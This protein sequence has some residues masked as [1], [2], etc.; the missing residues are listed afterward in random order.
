MRSPRPTLE[1]PDHVRAMLA[2][3]DASAVQRIEQFLETSARS[4]AYFTS[5]RVSERP[6]KRG[7]LGRLTGSSKAEPQLGP[8]RSKFGG[9]P[10][11][12][13][14]EL[15]WGGFTFLAQINFAEVGAPVDGLPAAGILAIDADDA[16]LAAFRV[17]WYPEPAETAGADPGPVASFG[18]YEAEIEFTPAW[19][20]P[21]GR[22]WRSAIPDGDDD[23]EEAWAACEPDGFPHECDH[24]LGGHRSAGLDEVRDLPRKIGEYE[25]LL[26][27][28]HDTA[29]GYAWGNNWVYV[30]LHR[31]DL[32]EGRLDRAVVRIAGC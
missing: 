10:F 21:V 23:L 16:E 29:A 20:W 14:G 6:L 3:H 2:R 13:A 8:M 12:T 27:F 30:I 19:S 4:C 25:V 11:V 24:R 7:V 9:R 28:T 1:L 22:R 32:A 5:R 15:P 31:D 26:C 18:D 17:R